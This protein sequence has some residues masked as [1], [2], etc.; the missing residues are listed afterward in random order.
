MIVVLRSIQGGLGLGNKSTSLPQ[1]GLFYSYDLAFC[2][3]AF[4]GMDDEGC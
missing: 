1:M 3:A 2:D 4:S